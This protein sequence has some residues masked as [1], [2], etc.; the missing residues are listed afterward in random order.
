MEA[1]EPLH[2]TPF[3]RRD[4]QSDEQYVEDNFWMKVRKFAAEVPFVKKAVALY[5]CA[6]DPKTPKWAKLAAY[7]ALAYFI[8]PIDVIP[9]PLIIAGWTD[10]AA[11]LAGAIKALSSK[12]TPEHQ[13]KARLWAQGFNPPAK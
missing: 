4:D 9:D 8:L 7:S 13:E 2:G 10:D 12:L 11:I 3:V 5:F 6:R 1:K